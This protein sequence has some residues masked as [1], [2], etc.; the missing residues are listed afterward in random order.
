M[1]PGELSDAEKLEIAL[2]AL[3]DIACSDDMTLTLARKKALRIYRE[4][5]GA[6]RAETPNAEQARS[7]SGD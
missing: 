4:L 7:A 1:I 2:G 3:A 6:E 5:R